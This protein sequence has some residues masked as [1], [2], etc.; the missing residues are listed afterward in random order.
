MDHTC[1][2]L[3]SWEMLKYMGEVPEEGIIFFKPGGLYFYVMSCEMPIGHIGDLHADIC[4]VCRKSG[5]ICKSSFIQ[6]ICIR[7]TS[8]KKY[9]AANHYTLGPFLLGVSYIKDEPLII[10]GGGVGHGF[11]T[12]FFFLGKEALAFF[13]SATRHLLF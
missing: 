2:P 13:S 12:C 1:P 8:C 7:R 3:S 4:K 10:V 11:F 6:T 5:C 9:S